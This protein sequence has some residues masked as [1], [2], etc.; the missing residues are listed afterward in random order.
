MV[1][2][3]CIHE[4]TYTH[5]YAHSHAHTHAH[6][7]THTHTHAQES[8]AGLELDI[9]EKSLVL[10]CSSPSYQLNVSV[11]HLYLFTLPP[12]SL[13]PSHPLSLSLSLPP[14]LSLSFS[15][16]AIQ[17]SC[18]SN[19]PTNISFSSSPNNYSACTYI[20]IVH[21]CV[22]V[23]NS[24]CPSVNCM[25]CICVRNMLCTSCLYLPLSLS[26]YCIHLHIALD[27]VG[28]VLNAS[29]Y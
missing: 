15:Q 17:L 8:A 18:A 21:V 26:R 20:Y 14:M 7:H 16:L 25:Y 5:A 28:P 19:V 11:T 6:T 12:S 1:C 3:S 27:T 4:Q 29:L 2:N 23:R 24:Q 22:P 9:F 13:P 10:Q